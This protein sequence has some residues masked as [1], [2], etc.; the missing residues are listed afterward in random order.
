MA[1]LKLDKDSIQTQHSDI[2]NRSNGHDKNHKRHRSSH[3]H[4]D[5]TTVLFLGL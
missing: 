1:S 2:K 3:L 4:D 5:A